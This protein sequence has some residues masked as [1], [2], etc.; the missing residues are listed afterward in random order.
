[1]NR[2]GASKLLEY[3][4]T[5]IPKTISIANSCIAPE[6]KIASGKIAK[7]VVS[8]EK[9]VRERDCETLMSIR[10]LID[11]LVNSGLFSLTRSKITIT[12]FNEYPMIVNNAAIVVLDTS[13]LNMVIKPISKKVSCTK[14]ITA[15][16]AKASLNLNQM[17][18]KINAIQ[19][20]TIK[21]EPLTNV[22]EY[23]GPTKSL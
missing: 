14:V 23:F 18:N 2:A 5:I 17:Y 20:T 7:I 12:L 9:R 1:M 4:P 21:I 13:N 19:T 6:A 10:S 22:L 11:T 16:K 15:A 8:D 3:A